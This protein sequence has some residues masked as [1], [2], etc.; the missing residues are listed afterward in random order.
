[1]AVVLAYFGWY[2]VTPDQKFKGEF[3]AWHMGFC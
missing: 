3:H 1:M 2:F